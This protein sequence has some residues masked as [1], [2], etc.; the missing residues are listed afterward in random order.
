[1]RVEIGDRLFLLIFDDD[2][3]GRESRDLELLRDHQRYGLS[4][5]EN[6]LVVKWPEWRAW[7]GSL[8]AVFFV[9]GSDGGSVVVSEHLDHAG[10]CERGSPIDTLDAAFGNRT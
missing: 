6:S 2:K 1:M 5:K 10:H 8:V 7:R 9:G 3:R 4:G